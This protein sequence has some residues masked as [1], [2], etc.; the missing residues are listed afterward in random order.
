MKNPNH[1][2]EQRFP[3]AQRFLTGLII[4]LTL[5][6]TAFEW[7]STKFTPVPPEREIDTSYFDDEVIMLPIKLQKEKIQALKPES[8]S[9]KI[10]VVDDFEPTIIDKPKDEPVKKD[11]TP[12][13]N[14]SSKI[15]PIDPD[16]YGPDLNFKETDLDKIHVKVEIFAHYDNCKELRGE[17]LQMCSELSIKNEVKKLFRVTEQMKVIGGKQGALMTFVIDKK[18]NITNIET[19]QSNNKYVAKAAKKAIERL[20]QMNPAMQQGRAVPLQVKI[21]IVVNM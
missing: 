18:G 16:A 17:E 10:K 13:N 7:T 19:L 21:P 9:A 20:P 3:F 15:G 14:I 6:L 12:T 5:S 1:K 11:D 4:A 8:N 2:R